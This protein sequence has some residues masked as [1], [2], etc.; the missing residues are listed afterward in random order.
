[1]NSI[2]I[3]KKENSK[4]IEKLFNQLNFNKKKLKKFSIDNIKLGDLIYDTYLRSSLTPSVNMND[5]YFKKV[6]IKT[7]KFF[8]HTKKYF[9]QNEVKAVIPSHVCYYYGVISRIAASKNI[10]I[11]KVNSE[12]RGNENYR[13]NIVDNKFVNE[14]AAPY[15]NF[16]KTFAKL[17]KSEKKSGIL[18][19]KKI[20]N[21]RFNGNYESSLSYMKI[22]QFNKNLKNTNLIKDN[23]KRKIFIFPHCYFDNVHRFRYF[24]FDDFMDQINYILNLSKKFPQYDWYYKP[25]THDLGEDKKI[26]KKMLKNFPNVTLL[27]PNV[28]HNQIIKNN[29]YCVITN[30]GTVGHEY[31]AFK[32]PVIFTG[33]NKHIDYNFGLHIKSKKEIQ[34]ALKNNKLFK[35]KIKFN[36][37]NIY[38]FVF[39]NYIY[40]Q[41]LYD[42]KKLIK[43]KYFNVQNKK[44][45]DTS[46]V[47]NFLIRNCEET[48]KKIFK[49][50]E[51]I[52]LSGDLKL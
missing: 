14:E 46:N 44:I 32:I 43:D 29:P 20:L 4:K 45:R 23:K 6:F 16:R 8:Y 36:I 47:F 38:E 22:S 41:N 37:E 12:N 24:L 33:D 42:R 48:D 3:S 39:M 21:N 7:V 28:S 19:G 34:I 11:I 50:F 35:K 10:P 15:F 51:N 40:Y 52:F 9:N 13:V 2:L 49:Y 31:A 1:M 18:D 17:S 25:H 26:H 27:K 30:H 5:P